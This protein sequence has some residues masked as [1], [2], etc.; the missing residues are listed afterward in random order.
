MGSAGRGPSREAGGEVGHDE[1]ARSGDLLVTGTLGDGGGRRG[2]TDHRRADQ[3]RADEGVVES[4]AHGGAIYGPDA[5]ILE[6]LPTL[7]R[8]KAGFARVAVGVAATVGFLVAVQLVWAP[9]AGIVVQ[10]ALL[11]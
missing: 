1:D 9:P 8:S 5:P 2:Q 6:H 11:G 4:N 10:G 7:E 3:E